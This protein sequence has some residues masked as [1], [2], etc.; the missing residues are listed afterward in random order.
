MLAVFAALQLLVPLLLFLGDRGLEGSALAAVEVQGCTFEECGVLRDE[1]VLDC[2]SC[3][4]SLVGRICM[5]V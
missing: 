1:D 4:E 3:E 5:S 2:R